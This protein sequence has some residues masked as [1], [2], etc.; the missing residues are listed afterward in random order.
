MKVK[1]QDWLRWVLHENRFRKYWV[2]MDLMKR[3]LW[4]NF[5]E[6]CEEISKK[7][8]KK[9]Y[10]K[11]LSYEYLLKFVLNLII[12]SLNLSTI[13]RNEIS[14]E[15]ELDLKTPNQFMLYF[16]FFIFGKFMF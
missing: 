2:S 11:D 3:R 6:E 16:L 12:W 9:I 13:V 15:V 5:W 1:Y 4:N 14:Y 8:I 10:V 7:L